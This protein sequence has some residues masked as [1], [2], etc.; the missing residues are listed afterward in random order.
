MKYASLQAA[1]THAFAE[2]GRL[3]D[4]GNP[5]VTVGKIY[6]TYEEYQ[7][8][9]GSENKIGEMLG[10]MK[11]Q[12]ANKAQISVTEILIN[13]LMINHQVYINKQELSNNHGRHGI[14]FKTYFFIEGNGNTYC[15]SVKKNG[16]SSL[17]ESEDGTR[18][19]PIHKYYEFS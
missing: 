14:E 11:V 2:E 12:K 5:I 16:E 9:K 6:D 3:D 15:L 8:S 7:A 1:I 17:L 4:N 18:Y 13:A 10:R 19:T